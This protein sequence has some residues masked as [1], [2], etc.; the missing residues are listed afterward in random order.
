MFQGEGADLDQVG[1][2]GIV[3]DMEVVIALILEKWSES[4]IMRSRALSRVPFSSSVR[5]RDLIRCN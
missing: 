1:I 3:R 5:R 2:P 4:T